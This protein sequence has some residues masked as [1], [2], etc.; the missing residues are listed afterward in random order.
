MVHVCKRSC[1]RFMAD[2]AVKHWHKFGECIVGRKRAESWIC[3]AI[4]SSLKSK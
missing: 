3:K 1:Y 4:G 2:K